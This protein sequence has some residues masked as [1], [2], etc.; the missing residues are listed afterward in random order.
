MWKNLSWDYGRLVKFSLDTIAWFSIQF[1]FLGKRVIFFTCYKIRVTNLKSYT[2]QILLLWNIKSR[3]KIS[4][5]TLGGLM[6]INTCIDWSFPLLYVIR[7]RHFLRKYYEKKV[8]SSI[9]SCYQRQAD[10]RFFCNF[11][12]HALHKWRTRN[13]WYTFTK[14]IDSIKHRC[15]IYTFNIF[16]SICIVI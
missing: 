3:A 12:L 10:H 1:H 13:R 16:L 9:S 5:Q 7:T 4:I 15:I 8:L 14:L 11:S 6:V 2:D